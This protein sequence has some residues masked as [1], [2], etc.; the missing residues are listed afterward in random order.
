MSPLHLAWSNL[1]QQRVRTFVSLVGVGFAVLLV[2]MQ[3]GFLDAVLRTATL[4][5]DKLDFDLLLTS[6]E[7]GSLTNAS[8][9]SRDRLGQARGV[10]GVESVWPL[11]VVLGEWREPRRAG[12]P[13]A[14]RPARSILVVAAD[15][16]GMGQLF[17]QPVGTVFATAD[18]FV[19]GAVRL[20]RLDTVLFDRKSRREYG[21]LATF[22]HDPRNELNGK[23]VEVAGGIEIGTGFAFNGLVLT[24][25]ATLTRVSGWPPG[26]VTFGL[27]RLSPG[28]EPDAV[29]REL[30]GL[31]AEDVDVYTRK[32]ISDKERDYWRTSTAVGQFF[33]A[34]VLIALAVG[35]VFVYQMMAAD[36]AKRLAEYATIRALGYP[37]RFLSAVVF[38]QGLF[39]AAVG[40]V[41]GLIVSLVG[42]E[43]AAAG[44]GA[45][46]VMTLPRALGVFAL[47]VVMCMGSALVAVREAHRA[48]P[49]DLF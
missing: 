4:L 34:G 48:N 23:Q 46:V 42:Y 7:Y 17:R 6:H 26:E 33:V 31:L 43:I 44:S 12:D 18:D 39:L 20:A 5:Y 25:E 14:P 36:I 24:S 21:D 9:F 35:G 19:E 13:D 28:A 45:P 3:L 38:W 37:G 8:S 27:V 16:G 49:A 41:P 30:R 2:F 11:T 40:Y 1:T 15:P 47:T 22:A 29:A 32:R 10:P